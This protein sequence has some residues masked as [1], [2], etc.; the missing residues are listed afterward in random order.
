LGCGTAGL[1]EPMIPRNGSQ[2]YLGPIRH[3]TW[4]HFFKKNLYANPDLTLGFHS[5]QSYEFC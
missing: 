3:E 4:L 1:L 2:E 5:S